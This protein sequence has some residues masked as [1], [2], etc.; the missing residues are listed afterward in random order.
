[1]EEHL[2]HGHPVSPASS[3]LGGLAPWGA[4]LGGFLLLLV[5]EKS[6]LAR[7][8]DADQHQ[9]LW[10][11]TTLGL[12]LHALT[13]GVGLS[14]LATGAPSSSPTLGP[15]FLAVLLHKAV[16][17]FSLATVMRLGG[18]G[19]KQ[20]C[21]GV[22]LF[23]LVTPVGLLAGGGLLAAHPDLFP[24]ALGFAA[25][26]FLYV[27]FL[28]LLPEVF[29]GEGERRRNI[30]LVG[31]GLAL[32]AITLPQLESQGTFARAVLD[33][34]LGVFTSMAPFLLLG[35]LA[36]GIVSRFLKPGSISRLLAGD[37]AA[38][39]ARASIIGAPL[40]LCS[41]SVLPVAATLRQS[42]ASRGATSAFLIA[43][44]ET[45]VDSV[46]VTAALLDPILTVVRPLAAILSAFV[47]GTL[48]NLF[49]KKHPAREAA[50][51]DVQLGGDCCAAEEAHDHPQPTGFLRGALHHGFV[52]VLD[53]LT[54]LLLA[55][56]AASAILSAL[57]PASLLA[58]PTAQGLSG[59][60]IMLAVGIPIYVCAAASTP[61]AA[62]LVLKGLSP[63][64]ALVF[65]LASPATN[66]GSLAV[67]TR[68][69]GRGAAIVHLAA[70]AAVTLAL[71]LAVDWL[72]TACGWTAFA[73]LGGEHEMLPAWLTNASAV[74]LAV[75]MAL[76]L[77][78]SRTSP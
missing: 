2:G 19:V 51:E 21:L 53:D 41:C 4:L 13:T 27:S 15:L 56:L 70:L 20:T 38:S 14:A 31:L 60:L 23:A 58:S 71:G 9:V 30:S 57:L 18:L 74:L 61:I 64:A 26:T 34:G 35:F 39:V 10:S 17:T 8:A 40:P 67:L 72:Y 36:A 45:G 52:E 63:G 29:H 43:T 76:S 69:L 50:D 1:G 7:S 75:L 5:I 77:L 32:T 25:G 22:T 55:G 59:H 48:V 68:I 66:L 78:R 42:G 49:L 46:T 11:A 16:E 54:P 12:S 6:G 33:E 37:D 65:L 73:R 3:L 24:L 62:S 44:P 47:T 28:D